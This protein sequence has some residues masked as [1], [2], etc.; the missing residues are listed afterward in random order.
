MH[1]RPE[2]DR[3]KRLFDLVVS[4]VALVCLAPVMLVLAAAVA[5]ALGRPVLFRQ[6]RAGRDGRPFT[7]LKFRT[8]LL[9]DPATGRV[10]GEAPGEATAS[11]E[12]RLTRLGRWLRAT[13]LDE[14]PNL[15]NVFR[16]EMSLVGPRPLRMMY[17]DR[18]T[19]EQARRLEVRPGITGLAQVRGRTALDWEERFSYDVK[20]VDDHDLALDVRIIVETV[21]LLVRRQGVV[22]NLGPTGPD[23]LGT[24]DPQEPAPTKGGHTIYQK[25]GVVT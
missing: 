18:Y 3:A 1:R 10:P 25:S 24:A 20:Y 13:S 14:L 4:T 12:A 17:L 19:P 15:W 7:M 8:M 11:D 9:A 6:T 16:G 5:A 21:L 2:R 22:A 23:F